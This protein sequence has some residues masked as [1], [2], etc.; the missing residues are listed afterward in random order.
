[1]DEERAGWQSGPSDIS[2]VCLGLLK[3]GPHFLAGDRFGSACVC[4]LLSSVT[5]TLE[6]QAVPHETRGLQTTYK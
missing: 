1:M 4:S 6:K 2:S 5:I 3:A